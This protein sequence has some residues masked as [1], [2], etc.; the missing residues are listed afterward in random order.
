MPSMNGV[1]ILLY[2]LIKNLLK[3]G[4]STKSFNTNCINNYHILKKNHVKEKLNLI[5]KITTS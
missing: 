3:K 5:G 1:A 4:H 2:T